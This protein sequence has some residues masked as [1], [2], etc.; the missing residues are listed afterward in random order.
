MRALTEHGLVLLGGGLHVKA[1]W[2]CLPL[3]GL[4]FAR[5]GSGVKS[6]VAITE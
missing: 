6:G 1:G 2:L 4:P 5:R 3:I